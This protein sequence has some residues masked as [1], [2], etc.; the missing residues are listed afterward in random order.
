MRARRGEMGLMIERHYEYLKIPV[1]Y[2]P[3]WTWVRLQSFV[4]PFLH[5][6]PFSTDRNMDLPLESYFF[7]VL[8]FLLEKLLYLENWLWSFWQP[9]STTTLDKLV[10]SKED[11]LW[12]AVIFGKDGDVRRVFED[13]TN[14]PEARVT[15]SNVL[16]NGI[17]AFAPS[18]SPRN[19]EAGAL[20][21]RPKTKLQEAVEADVQEHKI[22]RHN[23]NFEMAVKDQLEAIADRLANLSRS[24]T[25][26]EKRQAQQR[27]YQ[28]WSSRTFSLLWMAIHQAHKSDVEYLLSEHNL[29]L[30]KGNG[31]N[32]ETV[33]HLA[34]TKNDLDL[35]REIL[36]K[37]SYTS[38]HT[39]INAGEIGSRTA[40][41]ILVFSLVI[42]RLPPPAKD[43]ARTFAI[44]DLLSQYGANINALDNGFRTPLHMLLSDTISCK[45]HHPESLS[46]IPLDHL[47]DKL[48]QAGADVN[49]KDFQGT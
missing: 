5:L 9:S 43:L 49:T 15:S 20:S 7:S 46:A 27:G 13:L 22:F 33:L 17:A 24:L 40:I 1:P 2:P 45:R 8:V 39:H 6:S 21:H 19:I 25:K 26:K 36:E 29:K 11:E 48:L 12:H 44:F 47:M 23:E 14:K 35:T 30:N 34:V 32:Q 18:S 37:S 4:L 16:R 28:D 3:V 10:K 31:R 38:P 41:H 42:R